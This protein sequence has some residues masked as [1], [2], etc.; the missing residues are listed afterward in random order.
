M[1]QVFMRLACILVLALCSLCWAATPAAPAAPKVEATA[2]AAGAV[3]AAHEAAAA[4]HPTDAV[5][6]E[7]HLGTFI[8][9]ILI[10]VCLFLI[11]K[12][13]AWKPIQSGL[14]NREEAI[15]DSI[16]AARKAKEEAERTTR[17]L[18]AKMAEVQRQAGVQ[19]QQAKADALKIAETIRTQAEADSA[20]LKDRTLRE[21]DAAKQQAV[22]EINMHAAELGTAVARKILQRNVT[23]DDQQRLVDES[24]TEM[25]RKN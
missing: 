16:E 11:L 13:T 24:L 7:L 12:Q 15:R 8:T 3:G 4:E 9:T 23:A 17:E 14:K 25:A 18:E 20:A 22:S 2:P 5:G 21:I 1:R 19:L 6:E 10:F